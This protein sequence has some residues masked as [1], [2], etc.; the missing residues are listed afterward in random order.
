MIFENLSQKM[1]KIFKR[2][3]SKGKL[4]EKDVNLA[5]RDIK[6]A[7]LESDVSSVVVRGFVDSVSKRAVGVEVLESLTPGQQF[8]NVVKDSLVDLLGG[9]NVPNVL[10]FPSRGSLVV[11]MCGLQGSGKT[12]HCGKIAK[13][14]LKKGHRPLLVACDV[15]RPAAIK[16][17]EVVGANAGVKVFEMGV[18]SPVDIAVK[19]LSY[20][21]DYGYDLVILDTAGRLHVD[22]ELMG[23][24]RSLKS[25]VD[26]GETLFVVDAMMGQ[27]ALNAARDFNGKVGFDGVVLTK[28]DGDSRG[29]AALSVLYTTGKPI[30][31]VGVGE[32]VD[33]I[34]LFKPDSMASR[35]L[36]M[37][38]VLSLIEKAKSAVELKN[39]EEMADRLRKNK[40]DMDDLL[41]QMK[42]IRKLGS[43]KS[44]IGSIP[45]VAG[46]IKD[47]DLEKGEDRIAKVEAIIYSMT[48]RERS[49]PSI[50]DYSRKKRI[51]SGSG[52][53]LFDV[54][55]LL[56]QFD[57]MQKL[58]KKFG[59]RKGRFRNMLFPRFR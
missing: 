4:T 34:E 41:A 28:L 11:M 13:Y 59:G 2:L 35:I 15:Y 57:Q 5:V 39:V 42:Q 8:V 31:F 17:L 27:D 55:Q 14:Y 20:A 10:S 21:A 53:T 29:G 7:L 24:L 46:K 12:T 47:E 37:G 9:V 3:R 38:D 48:K 49:A 22:E 19:A 40:F 32:K 25:A 52:T 18:A 58:F 23:E 33:D 26:V 54:N 56:K 30:K 51:S 44:I 43:V 1:A 50:I 6:L 45:G 16:Q 36:G